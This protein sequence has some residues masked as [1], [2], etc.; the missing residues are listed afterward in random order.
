MFLFVV[1]LTTPTFGQDVYRN[2]M[3]IEVYPESETRLK[4]LY[5]FHQ[6]DIIPGP[7]P[8]IPYIAAYPEDLELLEKEGYAYEIIHENLEEFYASRIDSR[9]DDMGGYH[10]FDEIVAFLDQIHADHPTITTA[11]FSIGQSFEGREQWCLKISDNPDVDESEPEVFYN[12]LIHAR[13]PAAMEAVLYFMDYLTDNY[14]DSADATFL[15]DNRE[16]WFLPCVN[17]DGYVYNETTNPN[18]GGMWRKNRRNSY[19]IY[20]GVDLNRN[21]CY[22][23]GLDDNGSS[24]SMLSETYRGTAALSEP[25]TYNINQF[26]QSRNFVGS[27][28][29]HTYSNVILYPWGTDYF[30][31]NGLTDG[32]DIFEMIADSMAYFIHEINGVWYGTGPGWQSMY[33]VNGGSFDCEYGAHGMFSVTTEVGG[34]SDGFW[35]PPSRILPLAQENLPANLFF[36]RIA[37]NYLAVTEPNG[38][39]LWCIESEHDIIWSGAGFSGDVTISLNRDYP[40]G[41]WEVL[42]SGIEN[43]GVET[44]YVD[45]PATQNARIRIIRDDDPS[46]GDTSS[47]D[48]T[49]SGFYISLGYPNGGETWYINQP[50]KISW[51]F[52]DTGNVDISLNRNFPSG[53]WEPLF[54]NIPNDGFEKWTVTGPSSNNARIRVIS[55]HDPQLRDSSDSDFIIDPRHIT[56][57]EP[58][59]SET[60]YVG[61]EDTIRWIDEGVSGTVRIQINRNY[62]W[63]AQWEDLVIN[64]ENDGVHPWEVTGVAT[65]QARIR[66]VSNDYSYIYDISNENFTITNQ[67]EIAVTSPNG[68]EIW[69]A[70]STMDITWTS[71]SFAS[72]VLI[73]LDRAYPSSWDTLYASTDND[74]IESWIVTGPVSDKARIQI[75]SISEP[76]ISDISDADFSITEDNPPVIWYN[77]IDDGTPDSALFVA[78]VY[79]EFFVSTV[80]LFYRT[81]GA[82]V[83]DSTD[84]A[85]TGNPDE[86]AATLYLTEAGS[87]EYFIKAVDA[88]SQASATSVYDFQLYPICG[89][90]IY[91]DDGSADRFNW[92]G[93]EE[94]RW[95]V[96]FTPLSTP[97]ILCGARVSVSPDKPTAA[98]TRIYIEVYGENSGEPG[99]LLF[100]D[101]TGSIGNVIG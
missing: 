58:N 78:M 9:L 44:W 93:A 27:L 97:F 4:A 31:G 100:S 1:F 45:E 101:T 8:D 36:A 6:L 35:P 65:T 20:H 32:N 68:G 95:A 41:E 80:R 38:D 29:Y 52:C 15:V 34:Y 40:S 42:F 85:S 22:T 21:W 90:L 79:D 18:G 28:D 98:H 26:L 11:K 87:Y 61:F 48:F 2:H 56:V 73:K 72:T 76:S 91:Y 57:L 24:P 94:F 59:G 39:E 7:S 75:A 14:G 77:P 46:I 17:P 83:Y 69:Y 74:G 33:S 25:E 96:K 62:P 19:T 60:W 89:E 88:A 63:S 50:Y 53:E 16:M 99:T 5:Q 23:W 66:V 81:L 49:I 43:D 47:M 37:G 84:M 86:Y 12:S 64:T 13:E 71:G 55:V 3:L 70:D 92:A 30:E 51:A 67:A 82:G 54:T 10:T